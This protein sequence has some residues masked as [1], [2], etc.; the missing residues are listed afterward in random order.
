MS[1]KGKPGS[2]DAS[3]V[4]A[5]HH[6]ATLFEESITSLKTAKRSRRETRD[7][8]VNQ[9]KVKTN[10]SQDGKRFHAFLSHPHVCIF[11]ERIAIFACE[12][13]RRSLPT[14]SFTSSFRV[15]CSSPLFHITHAR[16][17]TLSHSLLR[18]Q[19][20]PFMA[21]DLKEREGERDST[22]RHSNAN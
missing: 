7:V 13:P 1:R 3:R 11:R 15:S 5:T 4:T 18:M 6:A 22:A 16:T 8:D 17:H 10:E 9:E 19:D 21:R 2:D 14:L 12:F 20:P